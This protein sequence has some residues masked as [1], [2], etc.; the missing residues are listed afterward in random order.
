MSL[1]KKILLAVATGLAAIAVAE[2]DA[3]AGST[4]NRVWHEGNLVEVSRWGTTSCQMARATINKANT[5]DYPR[6]MWVWSPKT[7][8]SYFMK[9]SWIEYDDDYFSTLYQGRGAN[10]STINVQLQVSY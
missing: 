4:C 5:R 10:G 8:K 1:K 6:S 9:R 3:F 7:H 2:T